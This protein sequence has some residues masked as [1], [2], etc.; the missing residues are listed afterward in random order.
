MAKVFKAISSGLSVTFLYVLAVFIAPIILLL[1]GFS[2]LIAAPTLFGLKLYNIEVK[3]T[4]FTTEAT[5]FGCL[6]A[7]MVGLI[8]HFTIRFL[9]GLRKTVSEGSN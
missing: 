6:L 8:I 9:L 4:V 2:N 7:F 3:D 5:F 1:L